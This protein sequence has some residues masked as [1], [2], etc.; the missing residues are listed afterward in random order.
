[1]KASNKEWINQVG[2]SISNYCSVWMGSRATISDCRWV[3]EIRRREYQEYLRKE[4]TPFQKQDQ[5]VKLIL[6]NSNF[7]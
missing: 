4:A 1:M 3:R 2:L 7:I 6:D 5:G